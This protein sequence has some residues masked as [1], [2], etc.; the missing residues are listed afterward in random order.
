M[1]NN[2]GAEKKQAPAAAAAPA[3]AAKPAAP[4]PMGGKAEKEVPAGMCRGEGCKGKSDRFDFCVEHY[5][6]FKFGLINKHGRQ[7]PDFEK[8]WD[9]YMAFKAKS[10]GLRKV[11]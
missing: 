9:H 5:D 10:T 6:Q 4:K 3:Q 11:A 2:T 1:G 7:V 8:K